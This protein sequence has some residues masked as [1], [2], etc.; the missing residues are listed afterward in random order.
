M[1]KMKITMGQ[2]VL[3]VE[4]L[5]TPTAQRLYE[6]L[7]FQASAN[8][9]GDEVYFSTPINVSIE[10]DAKDIVEAGE[11]AVWVE[12]NCIAIGFGPTPI[13]QGNE[14]RLAAKTNI[15]GL[16]LTDVKL[17]TKVKD[18]DPVSVEIYDDS[19]HTD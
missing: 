16:S 18:G 19:V 17:L 14:I 7:P 11:L 10:T 13:S 6:A 2:V 4:L 8:T 3:E 15:W 1:R 12:G 9:W 5:D